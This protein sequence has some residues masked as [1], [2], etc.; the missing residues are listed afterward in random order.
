MVVIVERLGGRRRP[1]LLLLMLQLGPRWLLGRLGSCRGSA[2]APR[3]HG[4]HGRLPLRL[5]PATQ[6]WWRSFSSPEP[7][8]AGPIISPSSRY[9]PWS[10]ISASWRIDAASR[11]HRPSSSQ[12]KPG[13][14][15]SVLVGNASGAL[16]GVSGL[17]LDGG[18]EAI[19]VAQ[20]A[21]M[22]RMQDHLVVLVLVRTL[23]SADDDTTGVLLRSQALEMVHVGLDHRHLFLKHVGNLCHGRSGVVG[24]LFASR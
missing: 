4:V 5:L 23:A 18:L 12:P 24:E 17:Q 8:A 22:Q 10:D 9:G 15:L 2:G 13:R 7:D 6:W 21:L 20:H 14:G 1:L 3:K 16:L 19:N 11:S